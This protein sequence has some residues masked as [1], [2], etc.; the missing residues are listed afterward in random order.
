MVK[1]KKNIDEI[2]N[3]KYEVKKN[4]AFARGKAYLTWAKQKG[5]FI[6]GGAI[7]GGVILPP[8]YRGMV[9]TTP[10]IPSGPAALQDNT[11]VASFVGAGVFGAIAAVLWKQ[12]NMIAMT[13]GGISLGQLIYALGKCLVP[14][15]FPYSTARTATARVANMASSLNGRNAMMAPITSTGIPAAKVLA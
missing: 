6:A 10:W 7:V 15:Y 1:R 14:A 13:C 12:N 5:I 11:V 2:K 3:I 9:G 8:I 4:M